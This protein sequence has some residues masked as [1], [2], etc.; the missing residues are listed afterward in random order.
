MMD[1]KKKIL[2][3]EDEI[4]L[5]EMIQMRLEAAG[6]EVSMVEDGGAGLELLK[7][8]SFDL[9][10]MDVLLPQMDGWETTRR[11]KSDPKLKAI[12][13][14]FLTALARHEDH[15]KAN[16]VG[17]SDY[18]SKPFES[19]ELLKIVEKWLKK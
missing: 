5:A 14:V 9:I 15:L 19:E 11:I 4:F 1:K 17:G 12:P 7:K 16:E 2:I 6:Y 8:K 10:L 18:L 3:V 13:V